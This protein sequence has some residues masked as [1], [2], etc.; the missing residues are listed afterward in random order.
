M[1]INSAINSQS[2]TKTEELAK[3]YHSTSHRQQKTKSHA[4][5]IRDFPCSEADTPPDATSSSGC[6]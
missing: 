3:G 1:E 5:A 2:F 4:L 6:P